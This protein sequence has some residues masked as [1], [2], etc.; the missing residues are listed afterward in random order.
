MCKS[1]A[2]AASD[3]AAMNTHHP[4]RLSTIHSL[5]SKDLPAF[6]VEDTQSDRS[7]RPIHL[8]RHA[9]CGGYIRGPNLVLIENV[10]L[11]AAG[12][13]KKLKSELLRLGGE[14]PLKLSQLRAVFNRR[15][16]GGRP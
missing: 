11:G 15:K 1:D 2:R 5:S 9:D 7:G 8:R 10:G 16:P 14:N 12:T 6:V 13:V 4:W 3:R